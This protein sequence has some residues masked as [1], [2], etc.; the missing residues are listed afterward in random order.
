[1]AVDG[2]FFGKI[3][4]S[5]PGCTE[6]QCA[7]NPKAKFCRQREDVSDVLFPDANGVGNPETVCD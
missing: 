6:Q 7:I 5:A 3:D 1:M 2:K 4:Q